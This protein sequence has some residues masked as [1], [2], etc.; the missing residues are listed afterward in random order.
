MPILPI[1][2]PIMAKK[3]VH[4]KQ[5]NCFFWA[6]FITIFLIEVKTMKSENYFKEYIATI[7]NFPKPGIMFR[8][9]TPT[10]ENAIVFKDCIDSLAEIAKKYDFNK[11][12]CADARGFIFGA[13]L[14]YELEKDLITARKP[15]KLPRP[16]F[17]FSYTLEYGKN[18]LLISEGSIKENDR[19]LVVDDLLAT[20]GSAQ[21]M[22][23]LVKMS[24]AIPVAALF[25]IELP[26]LKGREYIKKASGIPVHSLVQFEG[27]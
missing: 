5:K 20:G 27:E 13:V 15:G 7:P 16:G 22:I 8:D 10:I 12:I 17:E 19:V 4:F 24:K 25:Y 21:A 2:T 9:I 26:E 3:Y 23:E 6:R 18:T 14:A 11:I 1:D